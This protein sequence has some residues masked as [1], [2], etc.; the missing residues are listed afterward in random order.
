MTKNMCSCN[1]KSEN[2]KMF[3]KK[4][5]EVMERRTQRR[6]VRKSRKIRKNTFLLLTMALILCL[7]TFAMGGEK[8]VQTKTYYECVQVQKGDT[9][10]EIAEEYKMEGEDTEQMVDTIMELNGMK[11]TN[12]RSGESIIVPVTKAS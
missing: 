4:W 3:E 12:V 5:G 1:I 10:W 9:I 2:E 6:V 8:G 7:G 11:N